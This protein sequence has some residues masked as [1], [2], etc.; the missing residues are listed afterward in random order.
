MVMHLSAVSAYAHSSRSDEVETPALVMAGTSR[1]FRSDRSLVA[2]RQ[3]VLISRCPWMTYS[4][5]AI[6]S[7]ICLVGNICI[8]LWK[9]SAIRTC[10]SSCR[11]LNKGVWL[12][13]LKLIAIHEIGATWCEYTI[14][15]FMMT[16][17]LTLI[18]GQATWI[19]LLNL[20][21]F[22]HHPS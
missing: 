10:L 3:L 20:I 13:F 22:R 21:Q 17:Q 16:S 15:A 7:H 9:I 2:F 12:S 4:I 19:P 5:E 14:L 18:N 8:D 6:V 11:F 1:V